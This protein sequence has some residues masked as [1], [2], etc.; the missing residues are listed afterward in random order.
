MGV[1]NAS[2]KMGYPVSLFEDEIWMLQR[3][4]RSIP[5]DRVIIEVGT[6]NGGSALAMATVTKCQ[7]I[8]IDHLADPR[9]S[10]YMYKEV[11]PL[12]EHWANYGVADQIEQVTCSSS[13]YVHDGRPVGMVFIDGGHSKEAVKKD[14]ELFSKLVEPGGYVLFHDTQIP[15]VRAVVENL[16]MIEK[17]VSMEA[18]VINQQRGRL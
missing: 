8:T 3:Y 11:P 16:D 4:A 10:D 9:I 17:V 7:I 13:H 12:P 1:L 14:W 15:G 5:P 18:L 2:K 6:R